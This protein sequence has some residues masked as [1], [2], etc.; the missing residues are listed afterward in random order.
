MN[1]LDDNDSGR[2]ETIRCVETPLGRIVKIPFVFYWQ[3]VNSIQSEVKDISRTDIIFYGNTYAT[4]DEDYK[5]LMDEWSK[6]KNIEK[7]K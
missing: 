2:K 4:V 3:E 5:T 7:Y 6:F 1:S